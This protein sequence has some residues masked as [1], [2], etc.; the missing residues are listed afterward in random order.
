M[1][2]KIDN[3]RYTELSQSFLLWLEKW[4]E[5]SISDCKELDKDEKGE[6]TS[7]LKFGLASLLDGTGNCEHSGK[8]LVP[9][10]G[11]LDPEN[12]E[13]ESTVIFDDG[14]VALHELIQD[15]EF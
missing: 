3:K 8:A 6:L 12:P 10:L 14:K 2:I 11:Y 9:M 13:D 15:E 4:I 5:N 7:S 1:E